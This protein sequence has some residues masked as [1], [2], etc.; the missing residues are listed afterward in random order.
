MLIDGYD[1]ADDYDVGDVDGDDDDD[2]DD[3]ADFEFIY[4]YMTMML[5]PDDTIGQGLNIPP[6][7]EPA[8]CR[9]NS[10]LM[11]KH[12][13]MGNPKTRGN[14]RISSHLQNYNLICNKK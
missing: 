3:D 7:E 6:L 14:I 11:E 13:D 9:Q 10:F 4:S 5:E 1:A 8:W 2:A 12:V